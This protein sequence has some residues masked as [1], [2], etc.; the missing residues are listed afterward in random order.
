MNETLEAMARALFKSWFVD[1]DPVRAKVEG[2]QPS[3]MNAET[4]KLFP[5]E[6]QDSELGEIPKG[7]ATARLGDVIE[8][9]RGY[10]LPRAQ[11]RPG[12]VPIVS[13]SGPSGLHD[14]VKVR[15]PGIVT[16]RYGTIG[17][18]FFVREDFWPLN[19]TLYV[20]DFKGSDVL[21]AYH[22]LRLVDFNKF[23][24]KAAVPGINRNHVHQH[25]VVVPPPTVQRTFGQIAGAW[26]DQQASNQAQ[27]RTLSEL[28]DTLLPR[29]VSGEL[30]VMEAWTRL[31]SA[32]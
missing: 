27:S 2:R 32:R 1:F 25:R 4:A 28:R 11:R 30:S 15:A 12:V 9:K 13:S 21:Y 16:G 19:T 8:L 31:E 24:D 3:G 22:L 7:W 26:L 5:S 20:R 6:F 10:D 23:S 29:L 18:V 14:E 17:E